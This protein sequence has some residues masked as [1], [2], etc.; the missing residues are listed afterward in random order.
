MTLRR[1]RDRT[2]YPRQEDFVRSDG[3]IPE[4]DDE[5][6]TMIED[7][8]TEEKESQ[9]L[10]PPPLPS[11]R[12]CQ[13][14][15]TGC[16]QRHQLPAT[17]ATGASN[18]QRAASNSLGEVSNSKAGASNKPL[19]LLEKIAQAEAATSSDEELD[20]ED[21]L[22]PKEVTRKILSVVQRHYTQAFPPYGGQRQVHPVNFDIMIDRIRAEFW[23]APR[24]PV[25]Y[26]WG[27]FVQERPP[28]GAVFSENGY[29]VPGGGQI[30]TAQRQL[31]TRGK[32]LYRYHQAAQLKDNGST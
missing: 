17:P 18:S 12:R 24:V 4:T 28:L 3:H 6:Y 30:T 25:E 11:M 1:P 29:L 23:H 31:V 15:R 19:T 13:Q 21:D 7:D 26:D 27:T 22:T 10:P 20:D 2:P 9:L 32:Q 8:D 14:P 5:S 16:Q